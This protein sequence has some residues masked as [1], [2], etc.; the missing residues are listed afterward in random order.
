VTSVCCMTD[1]VR[2]FFPRPKTA[3]EGHRVTTFEL[4]FDLVFVFAFTQVTEFMAESHSAM[5][6]LQGLLI[7]GYLWW[8]WAS[9]GWLAN[10]THVDE[11][12]VRIGM[13]VAMVAMFVVALV[14]PE[15]YEDLE[16]GL[17]GPVVFVVAYV[18][19]RVAHLTLY[20]IAAGDD[21]A[22]RRQV[23]HTGGALMIGA[24]LLVLGALVGGQAQTWI[25]A[26]AIATDM[27]LTYLTSKGGSWRV[28]SAAHWAERHGLVIILAL[29]ESI[30]SVGV[31]AAHE[32]I[33][34]PILV[35]GVLAITLTISLWWL[36]FDVTAIAAEHHLAEA[37][38]QKRAS[39][40][41]D[42]Y[43]YGHLLL[44][45]G[46][47]ISALGVESVI[48]HVEE[49]HLDWFGASA[50]FGGTSL[51]LAGHALFWKR[52]GGTWK[53]WRLIGGALLLA[54]LPVGAIVPPLPALGI[55]VAVAVAVAA[56]ETKRYSLKRS[57]I[58]ETR[59]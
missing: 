28:Q 15:A 45:A 24:A 57:K 55:V 23:L 1:T 9:Y 14:I 30:I 35:G 34:V 42:A 19:I 25:W 40:A 17:Y 10:Q 22:L 38:G 8:A 18:A 43:T 5:G 41:T 21:A 4:F 31:G 53:V 27:L 52:V 51:Y 37:K 46:I 13:S 49:H 59:E 56:T 29:G 39:M 11:G 12:V 36:Y 58:R 54:L 16:G 3:N 48:S 50:L 7:L 32:P 2:S 20:F 6:V 26:G 47:V 33:S 44:V